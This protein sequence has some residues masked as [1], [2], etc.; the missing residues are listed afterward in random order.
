MSDIHVAGEGIAGGRTDAPALPDKA[1]LRGIRDLD[2]HEPL[3]E[4][5]QTWKGRAYVFL[6]FTSV[7]VLSGLKSWQQAILIAMIAATYAYVPHLRSAIVAVATVAVIGL[8]FGYPLDGVKSVMVQERISPSAATGIMRGALIAYVV[9]AW[10][11]LELARRNKGLLIAR[12]P[13]FAILLVAAGLCALTCL[14]VIHGITRVLLWSLLTVFTTNIWFLCYGLVDQ[15]ARDPMPALFHLGIFHPFSGTSSVPWGK[16]A[17]FL[18]KAQA[19]TPRDLAVTQLKAI[20]LLFWSLVLL[21]M[22]KL[23]FFV[24]VIWLRVPELPKVEAAYFGHH[25]VPVLIGW[26][27]LILNTVIGAMSLTVSG[28]QAIAVARLAGFRLPR[29]T[30][31]LLEA[32]SLAE[33]WNRYYYYFKE[34]L[35]EFFFLPTFLRTFRNHP[36][37]RVFFATFMAAGV[38]NAIYHFVRR[39]GFVASEGLATATVNFTSYIFYC[40]VLATAIA[41]SQVR[42]TVGIQLPTSRLGR[43]GAFVWIWTFVVCVHI[44]G[45]ESR[46]YTLSERIHFMASLMGVY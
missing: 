19:K 43:F 24:S 3:I 29:N 6:L 12:R 1:G 23:V 36:R 5:A 22:E 46:S 21:E 42:S 34:L 25:A 32:R 31:R 39:I 2:K 10:I 16:G 41:I 9:M 15:R 27:S 26:V 8:L 18:K 38:G 7:L 20:K 17:A 11:A 30:Y 35:V 44:F 45:D 33:Y 4:L 28:H 40:A 14:P 13:V 37:L